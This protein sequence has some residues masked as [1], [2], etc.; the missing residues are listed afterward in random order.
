MTQIRIVAT[1]RP[2]VN[3]SATMNAP[4]ASCASSPGD[5][6]PAT[7]SPGAMRA[8]EALTRDSAPPRTSRKRIDSGSRTAD[9]SAIAIGM[10][11]PTMKTAGHPKRG[12]IDAATRPPTAAP[13][14]NPQIII[15]TAPARRRRGMYSEVSAMAFGMAPPMPS[16]VIARQNMSDSTDCAVAV[17]NEPRPKI[18]EQAMSTGFRPMRSASGP[19]TSAPIIM[20]TRPLEITDPRTLREIFS[21]T[22]SAGAT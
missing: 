12:M 6:G 7:D 5:S 16:P 4:L 13:S 14:E 10:I 2:F 1:A 9:A 11:P 3:S 15:V 8:R 19:L 22:V 20:P 18:S 17:S 21:A